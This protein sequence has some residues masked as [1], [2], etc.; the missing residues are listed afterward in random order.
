MV[1]LVV[2]Q[3]LMHLNS[4]VV[5]DASNVKNHIY[6]MSWNMFRLPERTVTMVVVNQPFLHLLQLCL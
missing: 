1:E 5:F 2:H 4:S 6:V 3:L